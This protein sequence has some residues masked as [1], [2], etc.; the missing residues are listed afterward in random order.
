MSDDNPGVGI[1]GRIW[2]VLILKDWWQNIDGQA[3]EVGMCTQ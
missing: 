1:V 3:L 2:C